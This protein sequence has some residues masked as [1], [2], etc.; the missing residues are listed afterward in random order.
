MKWTIYAA[1]RPKKKLVVQ[2]NTIGDALDACKKLLG[3]TKQPCAVSK[4]FKDTDLLKA[5]LR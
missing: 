2:A 5:L 3:P 1:E 4:D